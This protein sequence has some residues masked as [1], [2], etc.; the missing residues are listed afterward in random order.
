[1]IGDEQGLVRGPEWHVDHMKRLADFIVK[2]ADNVDT[3]VRE[4]LLQN[5]PSEYEPADLLSNQV[6]VQLVHPAE[7][8]KEESK[9]DTAATTVLV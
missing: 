1:L 4:W 7:E 5:R 3:D 2:M 8:T 9:E 6:A